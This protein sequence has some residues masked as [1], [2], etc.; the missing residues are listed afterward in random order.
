M[1]FGQSTGIPIVMIFAEESPDEAE[2]DVPGAVMRARSAELGLI[3]DGVLVVH[4][5]VDDDWRVWIGNGLASKFARK[6]GTAAGLTESG[7][8]HRAKEAWFKEVFARAEEKAKASGA[9]PREK[10]G[11]TAAAIAGG[12]IERLSPEAIAN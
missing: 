4:F 2:D 7:E 3:D 8:M 5:P 9:D 12:L 1:A 11:V 10:L 6:P